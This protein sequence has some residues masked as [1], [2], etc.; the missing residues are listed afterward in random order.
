MDL[1]RTAAVA[2][3]V[4]WLD[5]ADSTNSV[6]AALA[7]GTQ[8]WPHGSVVVT[9]DQTAG[10][11]RLGRVWTA[12]PGG[13]LAISVLLRPDF[14]RAAWGW[15]PLLTGVAMADSVRAAGVDAVVKWPND[16][17][18]G[19]RKVCGV[20]AEALPDGSGAVIGA[21]LNHALTAQQLPVPTAT[22][23]AV[24]GVAADVDELVAGFVGTLLALVDDLQAFSGD[25]QASGA[26]ASVVA[27]CG[28]LGR[29]VR[30]GLPDGRVIVGTA[31]GLE[32]DGRLIIARDGAGPE[33]AP[34]DAKPLSVS[35]GDVEHLR[36]E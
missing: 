28:T 2:T 32:P 34:R 19:E 16:V 7:S 25:A 20:L 36:Y 22:S 5:H 35:A 12:P 9:D 26:R 23:L 3:R 33:D 14:P 21:G 11:G 30:V 10:R 15:L 8:P 17:L 13:S 18:V 4:R 27:H 31:V 1:P 24:L 6:L 29:R